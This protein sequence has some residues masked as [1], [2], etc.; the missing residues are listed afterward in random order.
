[1]GKNSDRMMWQST[2]MWKSTL[3]RQLC[4]LLPLAFVTYCCCCR[5]RRTKP[6]GSDGSGVA[7]EEAVVSVV[8]AAV[9]LMLNGQSL[10]G[11][12]VQA[13]DPLMSPAVSVWW[14]PLVCVGGSNSAWIGGLMCRSS[15]WWVCRCDVLRRRCDWLRRRRW[16][17]HRCWKP[18]YS[19]G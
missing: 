5:R 8:V 7:R 1:M 10:C 18:G 9:A 17:G 15:R 13:G 12:D 4:D 2:L 3:V 6:A 16:Q 11:I 19:R 14:L